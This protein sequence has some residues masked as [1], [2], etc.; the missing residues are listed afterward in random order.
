[1]I[2]KSFCV[3][4]S[5]LMFASSANASGFSI[6]EQGARAMG[7]A[8]AFA[9]RASDVS[10]IF[11]NPAGLAQ[12]SGTHVQFGTTLI[13]LRSEFTHA[14]SYTQA[15]LQDQL[16]YPSTFYISGKYSDKTTIGF[17]FYSPFGLGVKWD[18]DWIGKAIVREISLQ[19]FFFNP[20]IA[21]RA[22]RQLNIAVGIC[23]V[24]ANASFSKYV[25]PFVPNILI[26]NASGTGTG[27]NIGLQLRPNR[28]VTLGFSYRSKVNLNLEGDATFTYA[29]S[30][31][32]SQIVYE[33]SYPNSAARLKLNTPSM[34]FLGMTWKIYDKITA[35][36]DINRTGW[37]VYE[38]FEIDFVNPALRTTSVPKQWKDVF[39]YR[40]GLEYLA[41][42]SVTFRCG[43]Y[44]DPSPV[45]DQ[46]LDPSLPD[47]DRT[48]VTL[49]FGYTK[50][51]FTIDA[52]YLHV[53]VKDRAT[54]TSYSN[55]NGS[56]ETSTDL[57]G[58]SFG[59]KIN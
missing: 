56:Y 14:G 31:P 11:H 50:G 19:T 29:Y 53:F 54:E 59:Y 43:L 5:L 4:F 58:F 35:E 13:K 21:Y 57:F 47:A 48:G 15:K 2:R 38:N 27:F 3:I 16:F 28:Q 45:D 6:F 55:F 40:F 17:G 42:R 1:M 51:K 36:V 18:D 23:Y 34:M 24:K 52:A 33:T 8:G 7:I 22:N 41:T 30:D 26:D 37:S 9:A 39:N 25:H 12:L 49:G 46:Y 44:Q 32:A 10:A 20:V